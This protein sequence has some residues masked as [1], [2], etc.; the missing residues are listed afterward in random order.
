[1]QNEVRTIQA[2]R[3]C[4]VHRSLVATMMAGA[5]R[6]LCMFHTKVDCDAEVRFQEQSPDQVKDFF[7]KIIAIVYTFALITSGQ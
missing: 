4:H 7:F 3:K 6:E 2:E 5:A 1:M